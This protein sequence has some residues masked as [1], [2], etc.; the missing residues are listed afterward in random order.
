M[1]ES[2]SGNERYT[3]VDDDTLADDHR[4]SRTA[5]PAMREGDPYGLT[6][7]RSA[8]DDEDDGRYMITTRRQCRR[9]AQ[10]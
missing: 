5:S 8:D 10:L 2:D 4:R 3:V 6:G 9:Y 7:I 1:S